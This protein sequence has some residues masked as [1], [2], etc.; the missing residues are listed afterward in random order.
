[1]DVADEHLGTLGQASAGTGA[2]DPGSRRRG[3]DHNLAFE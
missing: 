2:A 1:V 3:D